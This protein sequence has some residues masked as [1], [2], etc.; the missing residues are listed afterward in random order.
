MASQKT[1]TNQS[2]PNNKNQ[3]NLK[4]K[5]KY[6]NHQRKNKIV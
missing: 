2:K 5:N 4:I 6:I 3:K 1:K